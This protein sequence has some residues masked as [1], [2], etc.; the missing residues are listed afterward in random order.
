MELVDPAASPFPELEW[1][2]SIH[3][4][5]VKIGDGRI[6]GDDGEVRSWIGFNAAYDVMRGLERAAC[7]DGRWL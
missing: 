5:F 2:R 4:W 3:L 1:D 7:P 6:R